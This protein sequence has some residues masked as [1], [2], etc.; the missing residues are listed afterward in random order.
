MLGLSVPLQSFFSIGLEV[1]FGARKLDT[2]MLF[3]IVTLEV[4]PCPE[5]LIAQKTAVDL[6]SV[7]RPTQ[8]GCC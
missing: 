4:P 2:S 7:G 5:C 8:K 6:S 3:F 1:A